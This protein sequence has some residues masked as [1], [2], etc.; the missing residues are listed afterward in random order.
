MTQEDFDAPS[1]T[2]AG[3]GTYARF[4]QI[5]VF[6]C[7]MH[8]Q[9]IRVALDRP[10]HETGPAAE[11]SLAEIIR[12]LGYIVGKRGRAP[13]GSSITITLTGPIHRVLHVVVDGRARVVDSLDGPPTAG[14]ALS[15]SLFLRL[16]GG[17]LDPHAALDC[18]ELTGDQELATRIAT[19]LAF[20]I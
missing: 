20:T 9:D 4:M 14:V 16:A 5:R 2:P 12:A 3:H 10:G 8:E 13:D 1:W 19:N 7:W 11:E 18:I 6:D 15:S 17:R